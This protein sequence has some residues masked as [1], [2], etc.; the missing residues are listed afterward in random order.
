MM[1]MMMILITNYCQ[2]SP[3][4]LCIIVYIMDYVKPEGA[5]LPNMGEYNCFIGK[6][7]WL[8]LI[9]GNYGGR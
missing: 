9:A 5:I 2:V 1:I 6:Y 8:L 4:I 3:L 7:S